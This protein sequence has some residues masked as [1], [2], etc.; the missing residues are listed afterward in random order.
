M[1][2]STRVGLVI[3]AG[4]VIFGAALFTVGEQDHL[5]RRKVAYQVHFARSGG[6]QKGAQVSLSGVAIGTVTDMEF[7][8]DPTQDFI[9]VRIEVESRIAPR[10]REHTVASIHTFGLLGDRYIE[11][12][13]GPADAPPLAPGSVIASLDPLDYEALFGQSGDIVTNVAEVATQLRDLLATINRGEGLLGAMVRNKEFGD[14]TLTGLQDTM[15]HLGKTSASLSQIIDRVNKGE[16]VLGQLL[17]TTPQGQRLMTNVEGAARSLND[18]AA[19]LARGRGTVPRLFEDEAYAQRM[20]A[21]LDA[22]TRNLAEVT[23][24][25]N[26]GQGTLGRLVNDPSLY[27]DAQGVLGRAKGNWLLRWFV[28]ERDDADEAPA[29]TAALPRADERP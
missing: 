18:V 5:W 17:R 8:S 6:L 19:R 21:N 28:G 3:L 2:A 9:D 15:E 12:A 25:I 11:L 13:P 7:P 1:G 16:G 23:D 4:L 24:K 26:R 22:T 10:I 27:E 14:A 20:L 29:A